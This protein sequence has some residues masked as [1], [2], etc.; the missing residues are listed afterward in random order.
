MSTAQLTRRRG[1]LAR[2][3]L[4]ST[5]AKVADRG[6]ATALAVQVTTSVSVTGNT[7]VGNY[8]IVRVA[9]NNF[10]PTAPTIAD[11]RSNTWTTVA[12]ATVDPELMSSSGAHVL[13]YYTKVTTQLVTGDLITITWAG[14]SPVAKDIVVEEWSGI[15]PTAPVAVAAVSSTGIASSALSI[16]ITPTAP[17]QLVYA[18]VAVEGPGAD[19]APNDTDTANGSWTAL[20]RLST[21]TGTGGT[22]PQGHMTVAGASKVVTAAGAQTWNST[23]TARDW[24]AAAVVFAPALAF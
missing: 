7:T 2:R 18:A 14:G 24:V 1:L 3:R 5:P 16:T 12:F 22:T 20:T 21:T 8:L 10:T 19:T 9:V 4:A 17:N 23:I 6:S 11:A 13:I 15:H